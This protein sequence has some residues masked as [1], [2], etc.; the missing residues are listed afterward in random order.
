MRL[1]CLAVLAVLLAGGCSGRR[2]PVRRAA[3]S[4]SAAVGAVWRFAA[5]DHRQKVETV[6][7]HAARQDGSR[8]CAAVLAR[9]CDSYA[10]RL[11]RQKHLRVG[12]AVAPCYWLGAGNFA[13]P[14]R[15]E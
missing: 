14:T 7:C 10:V 13:S 3:P 6:L 9:T 1:A 4:E 12:H 8:V 5:R 11:D 15:T 2:A